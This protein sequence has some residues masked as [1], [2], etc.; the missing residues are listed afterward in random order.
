MVILSVVGTK[1]G[2]GKTTLTAN[3]SALAADMGLR[4][5]MVDADI[6][7]SLSKFY[8]LGKKAEDGL[9][10]VIVSGRVSESAISTTVWER[11]DIIVC[12]APRRKFAGMVESTDLEQF[13]QGRID[14]PMILRKALRAPSSRITTIWCSSIPRI[15]RAI[16]LYRRPGGASPHIAG[17]AGNPERQR[18]PHR[19]IR[20]TV[21]AR[22]SPGIRNLPGPLTAVINRVLATPTMRVKSPRK[23]ATATWK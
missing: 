18:V 5:L 23:Y 6:Q 13:I 3:L 1:G 11:L 2:I 4:V 12:D 9:T 17:S 10:S 15:S 21:E 7:G 20:V 14:A 16:A 22:R 8:P 19:N